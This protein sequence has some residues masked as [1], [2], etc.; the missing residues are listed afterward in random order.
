MNTE[1]SGIASFEFCTYVCTQSIIINAIY[2][3]ISLIL[4]L[5]LKLL[6][7]IRYLL[8]ILGQ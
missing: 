6:P 5:N 1:F 4:I 8:Q 7:W 3:S 2:L